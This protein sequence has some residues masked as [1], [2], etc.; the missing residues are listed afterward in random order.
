MLPYKDVPSAKPNKIFQQRDIFGRSVLHVA[1]LAN[2]YNYLRKLLRLPDSKAAILA[3]DSENGWNLLHYI[4]HYKRVQ[5][6]NVLLEFLEQSANGNTATLAE[7][8]KRKDRAKVPPLAL[9]QND[10]KDLVF[11]PQYINER[12]EYHLISRFSENKEMS[13]KNVL[14]PRYIDH[15]WWH[16]ERGGLDLYVFGANGNNHLGVGD[17]TDRTFPSRVSPKEFR[18]QSEQTGELREVLQKPRYKALRVSKYHSLVVLTDGR[19]FSCGLGSRGRLGHGNGGNSFKFKDIEALGSLKVGLVAISNNHN[20]VLTKSNEI[21][22]WGLNSHNQ[23]GFTSTPLLSFKTTPELYENS[24]K[25]VCGGDL[26]KNSRKIKGL[27]VS[28]IHSVAYTDTSVVFWGL[29]IGQMGM[30]LETTTK[31]NDHRVNG[32]TYKGEVVAQPREGSFR[33]KIRLV[34]TCETCTC[35]V[36]DTNDI[37]VYFGGQ[38][39]K[40]PKLPARAFSEADFDTFK[41]SRLTS[42]PIIKKVVLKSH[43]N[44]HI[45]LE[46]GDVMGFSLSDTKSLRNVKYTYIWRAYDSD[47]R[48][49]DMDNSYDGQLIV[50]TKNGSVFVTCKG[51]MQR[52]GSVSTMQMHSSTKQKFKKVEHVNRVC[53]VSCDETFSSFSVIRDDVDVLPLK[54]QKNDLFVDLTYLSVLSEQDLYR[55]QDQLLDVDHNEN[56]YVSRYLYPLKPDRT[57]EDHLLLK[58]GS[59]FADLDVKDENCG[60]YLR[61]QQKCIYHHAKNP[62]PKFKDIYQDPQSLERTKELLRSETEVLSILRDPELASS[63]FCDGIITF[64][65]VPDLEIGFH[66]AILEHRSTFCEQIFHPENEGEYFVHGH[67]KGHYDSTTKTLTFD[68]DVDVRAVVVLLH[69]IY[70]NDVASFWDSYP[71]GVNCPE[72]VRKLKADY[73]ELM[74]LF[75]MDSL[76]GKKEAFVNHIQK[77]SLDKSDG[78]ILLGLQEGELLS[79]SAVLVARSA[80][81]ETILSGRWESHAEE[82]PYKYV[83][84]DNVSELQFSIIS[85]HLHGCSDLSVFDSAK[86]VVLESNDSDDFVNFLLDMIEV[87]DEL[88]LV[89]L[90]HLCELAIQEFINTDNVLILLGHAD[91]LS[92]HKLFMSC[93]WYVYNNLEIV[94]FDGNLRNLDEAL[95][96]RLEE[97]MRFLDNCKLPEF[98]VGEKGEVNLGVGKNIL[99]S[100][101]ASAVDRFINDLQ[102][103]NEIY[104]SDRKGFSSFEP[105]WDIKTEGLKDESRRKLSSRRMSR[106]GSTDPLSELRNISRL[107]ILE[108]KVSDSAL[109][110]EEE[111]EVVTRRRKSKSK[112]IDRSPT[113]NEGGQGAGQGAGQSAGHVTGQS[114]GQSLSP[115]AGQNSSN[116]QPVQ[117]QTSIRRDLTPPTQTILNQFAGSPVTIGSL[118]SAKVSS[119]TTIMEPT[120]SVG[121]GSSANSFAWASRDS[122]SVS[123]NSMPI[124]REGESKKQTKIKFAPSMKLSQKQRKK[125]AQQEPGQPESEGS[126]SIALKNPWKPVATPEPV[127]SAAEASMPV[128]GQ[129]KQTPSLTAIMLQELTRVEEQKIMDSQQ[130][131]LQE[132][133]QEQEFARWW[134]EESK[135]VQM[136]SRPK[137]SKENKGK[138][139]NSRKKSL[140]K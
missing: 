136:E 84:M 3:T 96:C 107:Q 46:S 24:P 87:A 126:S 34:A 101:Q 29:N 42:A 68:S 90:K 47:M 74:D 109:V 15:D 65:Q 37:H 106:R 98:L 83:S 35:I 61:E 12:N 53:R 82:L 60:D 52:R 80:F 59:D 137:E 120:L 11:V 32:V 7:L 55:K 91:W 13:D 66:T 41:P 5:C 94:L 23:L 93:C 102:S 111:F 27:A 69:F 123:V 139:R 79:R 92:A 97:Q 76:H 127:T 67:I 6:L 103:F 16:D 18:I 58:L 114:A 112:G 26:R 25:L 56:L 1:I 51:S 140:P 132:I 10:I 17:S 36:T 121:S 130:Q 28:K 119:T 131:T 129:P 9:L 77:V 104:M 99:E 117:I 57:E 33:D 133:Q 118:S 38:R 31:N 105:L 45:L 128:L 63:K 62:E 73:L 115:N 88:L 116:N 14:L 20:L 124:S 71:S 49:V 78:D 138:R 134:A 8:L 4:F 50:C 21:Y 39:V 43:E 44:I 48:A 100:T 95:V 22:A 2:D 108:R 81:F 135:R 85:S 89:Q 125:L 64:S 40:L 86:E 19:V 110:D 75:R 54:L 70:T 30:A 72:D 122:S 113:G